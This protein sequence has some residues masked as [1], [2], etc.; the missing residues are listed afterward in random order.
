MEFRFSIMSNE[1]L[2]SQCRFPQLSQKYDEALRDAVAY[3]LENFSPAGIIASGTIIRG[4]PDPSSDFDIYAIHMEPYRQRVQ[5]FFRGIPTE[6]FVNPPSAIE[7]YYREEHAS[8]RPCTAHMILSG[9]VILDK[10]PLI[11]ELRKKAEES[12][13]LKPE[14]SEFNLINSRY[15]AATSL[16]DALDVAEKDP[17][18]ALMFLSKAVVEMLHCLFKK[19]G[20][21]I[22]RMKDLLNDMEEMDRETAQLAREFYISSDLREKITIA[23]KIADRTIETRGFFEWE[24]TREKV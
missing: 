8:L 11:K 16:E 6:I 2:L 22:P 5:K 1:S 14:V 7:G 23:E 4:N 18:T 12:L 17:V 21:F 24:S 15:L 10:T 19:N 20:K 9:F 13:V 3:I